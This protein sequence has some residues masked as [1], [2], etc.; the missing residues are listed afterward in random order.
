LA[1]DKGKG[2]VAIVRLTKVLSARTDIVR[3]FTD[4]M[5]RGETVQAFSDLFIS[6]VSLKYVVDSLLV[7]ERSRV[8]GIFHLS[9]SEEFSYAEFARRLAKKLGVPADLI[10]ETTMEESRQTVLYCPRHPTLDMSS[11]AQSLGL[12]PEPIDATVAN[13]LADAY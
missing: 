5:R 3:K 6:P 2:N 13:V 1:L 7:V 8:G 9:G 4:N 10:R 12:K 11:T